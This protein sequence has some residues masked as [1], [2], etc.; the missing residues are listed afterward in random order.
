[1]G[2]APGIDLRGDSQ[3]AR[4]TNRAGVQVTRSLRDYGFSDR[5]MLVGAE[6]ELPYQRPDGHIPTTMHQQES[7]TRHDTRRSLRTMPLRIRTSN[8]TVASG[9]SSRLRPSSSP[10]FLGVSLARHAI[11]GKATERRLISGVKQNSTGCFARSLIGRHRPGTSRPS[12]GVVTS[13]IQRAGRTGPTH[14]VGGGRLGN[15]SVRAHV[16][17]ARNQQPAAP[18]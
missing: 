14:P 9:S 1:M 10:T 12:Q 2:H 13:R 4:R 17:P 18:V 11:R 7:Q 15:M 6:V 8:F 5:I 16:V 3:C